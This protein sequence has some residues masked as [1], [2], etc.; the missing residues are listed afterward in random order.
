[1][2]IIR[3]GGGIVDARGS[4]AGNT[5]SRNGAGPILRARTAG[6]QPASALQTLRQVTLR[7]CTNSWI[8]DLNATQRQSWRIY[9]GTHPVTN[10]LGNTTLLSGQQWYVKLSA[11]LILAGSSL[12]H[13]P[14]VSSVISSPTSF[15]IYANSGGG[16]TLTVTPVATA[17]LTG[18]V[19]YIFLSPALS[20]GKQYIGSQLRTFPNQTL[21]VTS[22]SLTGTY[23]TLFGSFP[24]AAG[25]VIFGRFAV[26][27]TVNGLMSSFLSSSIA[28]L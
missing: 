3:F 18:E 23:T 10:R 4:H 14:P 15:T 25:Q 2:A 22:S 17:A 7:Q 9:A 20:P 11:N 6:V 12:V 1:M 16:G 8:H 28:V 5:F 19:A 27:N 26:L 21:G 13:V 24:A